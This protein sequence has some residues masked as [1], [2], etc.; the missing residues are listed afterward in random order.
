MSG[1]RIHVVDRVVVEPGRA[2]EFVDA[3]LQ[4]YAPRARDA[5]LTLDRVLLSPPVWFEDESNTV[6]AT[7][8]V[9]GQ[10]QWWQSAIAR[11]FD[12]GV[13]QFWEKVAPLVSERSRSM[14]A[15]VDDVDGLCRV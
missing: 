7:W 13:A 6:T 1:A 10:T 2:R 15:G 8:T 11:R 4:E 3:Y 5:G 12:P 14:A 9:D